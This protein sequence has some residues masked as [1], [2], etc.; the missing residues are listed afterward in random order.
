MSDRNVGFGEAPNLFF[1]NYA[2]FQGRSSRGAFWW[3][4]LV[5]LIA[6]FVLGFIDGMIN[7]SLA[8]SAVPIGPVSGIFL[9]ATLIPNIALGMRRLHDTDKSGWW[10]LISLIPFV[11][12]IVLIVFYILPGT[13]GDNKFGA[14]VE[15][16]RG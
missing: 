12:A 13:A 9:L 14:N 7:P 15:A 4:V 10:L 3:W 16:G 11:G 5:S 8:M 1:K 6:G 2:N